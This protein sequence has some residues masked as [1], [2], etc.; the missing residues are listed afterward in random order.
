MID[1]PALIAD[2]QADSNM[3]DWSIQRAWTMAPV[4]D[5]NL[6]G[7]VPILAFYRG[8]EVFSKRVGSPCGQASK[9]PLIAMMVVEHD[10]EQT[11]IK[12]ARQAI[13]DWQKAGDRSCV[14]LYISDDA[15]MPCGPVSITGRYIWQKDVWFTEY[16]LL[17][18]E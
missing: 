2:L 5:E 15:G 9:S 11:R 14:H 16:D 13:L 8:N 1:I 10:D 12:Q 3:A 18:E 17:K 4:D 7:E 6:R